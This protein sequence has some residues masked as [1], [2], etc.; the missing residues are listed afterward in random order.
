VLEDFPDVLSGWA[1]DL[2]PEANPAEIPASRPLKAWWRCPVA[3]D[4]VWEA[5]IDHR[6]G[7][8]SGCPA[9]AGRQPSVTNRLDV[10]Q[11]EHASEWHPD[12]N[13]DLKPS[14]MTV[15][16]SKKVWWRCRTDPTHEWQ[17]SVASRT[18][19]GA[20]CP[21]CAT[22]ARA[23]HR[24]TPV[25]GASLADVH[26][27]LVAEWAADLNDGVGPDEVRPSSAREVWWRCAAGHTWKAAVYNRATGRGCPECAKVVRG[28]KRAR[29]PAG[30]SLGDLHPELAAQW[31]PRNAPLN[32]SD[33]N[34][35]AKRR[36]WW[37]CPIDPSHEWQ[38]TVAN[39]ASGRGCPECAKATR[40]AKRAAPRPDR[41]LAETNPE[42]LAEW[43]TERNAGLDPRA[44]AAGSHRPVWWRCPVAPDHR[45]QAAPKTRVKGNG[46]PFCRGYRASST[47]NLA[48]LHPDLADQWH[49][50]NAPLT[51]SDVTVG[52]A[53]KVW[54]RCALC[55]DHEWQATVAERVRGRGCPACAGVQLSV[56]NRLDAVR[57]DLLAS[58]HPTRNG[59]LRPDQLTVGSGQRVWWRCDAGPDHEWQAPVANRTSGDRGCPA[60]AGK[61]VSVTNSLE[62]QTPAVAAT[63][64]PTKNGSLTPSDVTAMSGRRAWWQCPTNPDH[65]WQATIASRTGQGVGCPLCD[66]KPRSYMEVRLAHELEVVIPVDDTVDRIVLPAPSRT[67][68]ISVDIA[69]PTIQ[70]VVEVD[71]SWWHRAKERQDRAK[72]AGLT[73][74]GWKVI[75]VREHPLTPLGRNDVAVPQRCDPFQ[76]ASLVLDRIA[77]LYPQYRAAVDRYQQSGRAQRSEQAERTI[78]L[79][80]ARRATK[81][82]NPR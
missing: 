61:Q 17:T 76:L 59:D 1:A 52:S 33:V 23:Q 68:R 6:C 16:S 28:A 71:G 21:R 80:L 27:G 47:N 55:R 12:K 8:G 37:R 25:Q 49:P 35:F 39:R 46:C 63:W 62:A 72:S 41:S 66:L 4:H 70:L 73:A 57:P 36:V 10:L 7:A 81:Q 45:W 78:A 56:T 82:G 44:V 5:R 50:R 54:W 9:C 15:G 3:D 30:T 29:P 43:D 58:W 69:A 40:G 20:G 67:R 32:P 18:R 77:D 26:P 34:P 14:R 48:A 74:A 31:H 64:H 53:K 19:L 22:A 24:R 60:C 2:N 65:E 13:G 79:L 75:R 51:S 38:A 11:P 42:L